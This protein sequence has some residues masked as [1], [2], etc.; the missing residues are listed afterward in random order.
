M[1]TDSPLYNSLLALG[2]PQKEAT[3]YL[4]LLELGRATVSEVSRKAG[5]KRTTGYVILDSLVNKKLA[6]ASGKEPRQEYVAESPDHIAEILKAEIIERQAKLKAAE[7]LIPQLKSIQSVT[8]RPKV[9]FYE[10]T[11]GLEQVYEDTLT[12]HE[13]I[14]GY[15]NVGEMHKA[16]PKYFPKYYQRRAGK[17]IA[18]RAIIPSN[19]PGKKRA[20]L[21]ATEMRESAI[22]PEDKYYFAPEINMYDNK[23]MI[24][25]WREKL[26][27]II[28]STEIAEAMKSI[29]ELAWTEAKRQDAEMQKR[30]ASG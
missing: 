7:E 22:I 29:F 30:S 17:G 18:V 16:L 1:T 10:G 2:L 12:A 15:A 4:A 25:S 14:R 23:V 27:I 11:Q 28:E 20:S 13:P 5:I 8:D 21:D 6:R 26:G 3:V 24:A 9:R 19:A